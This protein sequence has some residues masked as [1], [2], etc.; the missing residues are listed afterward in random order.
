M[1]LLLDIMIT[2]ERLI[3]PQIMRTES[4]TLCSSPVHMQHTVNYLVLADGKYIRGINGLRALV[5]AR[6]PDFSYEGTHEDWT[7]VAKSSLRDAVKLPL[8]YLDVDAGAGKERIV[9]EL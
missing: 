1:Q 9:L 4:I 8:A 3:D 7:A 6:S 2:S 5:E